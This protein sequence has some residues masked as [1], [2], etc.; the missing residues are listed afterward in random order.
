MTALAPTLK[1]MAYQLI[2]QLPEHA[3]W[4]DVAYRAAV[5]ADV[6]IKSAANGVLPVENIL[7]EWL[8]SDLVGL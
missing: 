4:H 6:E 3:T 1:Q 5:H 2:D 8:P 7:R